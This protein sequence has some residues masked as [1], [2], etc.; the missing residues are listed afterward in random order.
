MEK[1]VEE[2]STHPPT[3]GIELSKTKAPG[4]M[5]NYFAP[6]TTSGSQPTIKSKLASKEAQHTAKMLLAEWAYINCIPFNVFNSPLFQKAVDAMCAIGPG[7]KAPNVYDLRVNLLKDWKNEYKLLIQGHRANWETHGCTHM[8]NGWT[9][10]RDQ[11]L[12]NFLVYSIHGIVFLKSVD[13]SD[14]VKEAQTILSLFSN[15]IEYV[16]SKNVVHVVTDNATNYV[17][18]GKLIKEKYT[19]IYWTPCAAHCLIN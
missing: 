3:S 19:K 15:V 17:A 8:A 13:A 2:D 11:T 16:G 6:R 18:C 7:F 14:M 12:I 5:D 4:S 10:E 9:D 1:D